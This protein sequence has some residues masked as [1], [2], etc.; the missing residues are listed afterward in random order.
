MNIGIIKVSDK[1]FK[2]L[3]AESEREQE[4]GLMYQP[5]P[6]PTMS[7][8]YDTPKI[9]KFWMKNTP[10]ALDIV[11]CLDGKI[12]SIH[13]GQPY[14][15]S[16]IGDDKPSDLVVEFPYG[17]VSKLGIKVGDNIIFKK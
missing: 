1:E 6:P 14:S 17:T 11:F 8:V 5:F 4:Q 2:T 7:F 15:T 12:S 10:S 9:N 16:I 13:K 3:I